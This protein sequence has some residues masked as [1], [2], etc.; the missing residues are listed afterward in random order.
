MKK[1]SAVLILILGVLLVMAPASEAV[2]PFCFAMP[3]FNNTFAWFIEAFE[4]NQFI[5]SGRD[6]S[7]GAAQSLGGYVSGV[8]AHISVTSSPDSNTT[9]PLLIGASLLISTG[10]GPGVCHR[11]NSAAGCGTGTVVT[12]NPIACPPGTLTD[13]T[14]KQDPHPP[15]SD[16]QG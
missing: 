7:S 14:T 9:F 10:S 6:L 1:I 16:N 13:P 2:G 15:L 12:I 11:V 4:G 8:T 3:P 5:G